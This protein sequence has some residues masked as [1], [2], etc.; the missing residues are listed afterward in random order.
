L[1]TWWFA[2]DTKIIKVKTFEVP[3][4]KPFS[5]NLLRESQKGQLTRLVVLGLTATPMGFK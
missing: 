3:S 1:S 2:Q 4:C 5:Y